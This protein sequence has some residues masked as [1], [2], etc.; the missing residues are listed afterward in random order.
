MKKNKLN[1]ANKHEEIYNKTILGELVD[2]SVFEQVGDLN[3]IENYTV[4]SIPERNGDVI[5][6]NTIRIEVLYKDGEKKV[7]EDHLTLKDM[8]AIDSVYN[9]VLG[10]KY[11][12]DRN[13]MLKRL[14]N[15]DKG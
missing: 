7:F 6:G 2:L 4:R 14:K 5:I 3:E 11:Q 1:N 13:A 15:S 10:K 8:R 9:G 12:E